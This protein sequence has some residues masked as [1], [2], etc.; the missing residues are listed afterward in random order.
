MHFTLLFLLAVLLD[1][2]LG[3]P[4]TAL[5]PVR[6]FGQIAAW[7]DGRVRPLFRSEKVAGVFITCGLI[8][9]ASGIVSA[10]LLWALHYSSWLASAV[11]V[12]VLVSLLATRD[13]LKHCK[14]VYLALVHG[15]NENLLEARDA[16]AM[17]VG[18]DTEKLESPGIVRACV[19]TVA[20]NMVDGITAPV[21]WAVCFS[22]F[23]HFFALPAICL[24]AIG[25]AFYKAINTLD[26][27]YGY[28]NERYLHFGWAAARIDDLANW[29]AARISALCLVCASFILGYDARASWLI[30]LRDRYKHAS[31]NG[32]HTEAA[33]AG[34]LGIQLCGPT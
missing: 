7:A 9:I 5:H 16:L 3:D 4:R 18:R 27:M 31:P 23:T 30:F 22:L 20:E 24:A 8:V 28:K 10:L 29:P 12:L 19:E 32:G 13:L 33:M 34:A 25:M 11:A 6:L 26:S 17:I 2:I 21:F 1:L 15:S 14:R